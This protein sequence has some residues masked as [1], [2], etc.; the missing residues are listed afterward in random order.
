MNELEDIIKERIRQLGRITFAEFMEMA[1]YH[2]KLGYYTSLRERVGA[3]GDFFTSPASHPAFG[4]L[5]A[6]QL[7]Q[8]WRL[9]DC[10]TDFAVVEMGAGK[11]LL[12]QDILDYLPHISTELNRSIRY[13]TTERNFTSLL[14]GTSK[15]TRN[16][17]GCFLSN[18]LLD[19]L[20]THLV[21][22]RGGQLREVYIALQ[23]DRLVE[24]IDDL[25][26]PL[27]SRQLAE[28]GITLPEGYRTEVNLSLAPWMKRIARSLKRGFIITI[29]YG[30]LAHELYAPERSQGTLMTYYKHTC[31][32]EP[33]VRIGRQDMTSHVNFTGVIR[34]GE[35]SGLKTL[36]L[37]CQREFLHNLGL[38]VFLQALSQK[39]LA[40]PEYLANKFAMLE[41][42]RSEGMG[43]FKV[44]IQSKGVS[45]IPLYAITL[46]N[47]GKKRLE[48][49][50]MGIE[51]PL[52]RKEH[53]PLLAGRYPQYFS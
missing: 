18:E 14:R 3:D 1:L 37:M 4:A 39:G 34:S 50:L 48:A 24:V 6:I 35:N 9:L 27:L 5:I 29:D 45:D 43:S 10:P 44:M 13:V 42:A 11:G 49:N 52:L 38:D 7:R 15:S 46:N 22:V 33:Y 2:P 28:E 53:I 23:G 36:G 30:H 25:S 19:A 31:A 17:T 21:T 8:M 20:P 32:S 41:L 47:E 51:I 16:I 40:Q 26:T 12:A